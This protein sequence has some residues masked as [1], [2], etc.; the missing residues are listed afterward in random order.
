[1]PSMVLVYSSSFPSL[2]WTTIKNLL[3]FVTIVLC[4]LSP[5]PGKKTVPPSFPAQESLEY[6]ASETASVP[7]GGRAPG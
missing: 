7:Q 4:C 6:V 5:S 2:D 1:M 3:A